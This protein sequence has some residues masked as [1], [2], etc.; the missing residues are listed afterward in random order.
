MIDK[1]YIG[2]RN[3][4]KAAR[5]RKTGFRSFDTY[6]GGYA[7]IQEEMDELWDEVTKKDQNRE[8]M[9][10]EAIQAAAMIFRF[11]EDCKLIDGS[12]EDHRY[13]QG[14]VIK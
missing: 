13:F 14:K 9:L 12:M 10:K 1:I 5:D 8:A 4:L 3:E 2:V 7:V 6:L 11:I